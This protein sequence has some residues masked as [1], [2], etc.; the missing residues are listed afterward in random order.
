MP[1]DLNRFRSASPS[2]PFAGADRDVDAARELDGAPELD[3][4][5]AAAAVCCWRC[6]KLSAP[7][8]RCPVCG[9]RSGAEAQEPAPPVDG[10]ARSLKLLLIFCSALLLSSLAVGWTLQALGDDLQGETLVGILL[11]LEIWDAAVV[12]VALAMIRVAPGWDA[13]WRGRRLR[14]WLAAWPLLAGLLA[15]NL[16]YHAVLRDLLQLPDAGE[17]YPDVR[18][19]W[20]WYVGL[21]CVQPAIVEELFFRHTALGS[22]RSVLSDHAAVWIGATMFGLAHLGQPLSIPY[23]IALGG[24]LGYA[25]LGSGS[26]LLP[27]LLHLAHNG[28]VLWIDYIT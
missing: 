2:D 7:A 6:G 23:L 5:Q 1:H 13:D 25:R 10:A 18:R 24:L 20:V 11:G 27:M 16:A 14:A 12:L 22:L 28:V 3:V 19:L 9:A 21:I 8:A 26:L 15:I 4:E 17:S